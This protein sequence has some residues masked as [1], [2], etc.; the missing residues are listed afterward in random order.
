MSCPDCHDTGLIPFL[1]R[2]A[3]L[4]Y[5]NCQCGI[6]PKNPNRKQSANSALIEELAIA[7]KRI[8]SICWDIPDEHPEKANLLALYDE[9]YYSL[10][11]V[12]QLTLTRMVNEHAF[13]RSGYAFAKDGKV[14]C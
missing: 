3:E 5:Q 12:R 6:E 2:E 8:E 14:D 13:S 11:I 7:S 9:I 10:Q 4:Q 1:D